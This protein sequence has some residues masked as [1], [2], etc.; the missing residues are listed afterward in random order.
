M[1]AVTLLGESAVSSV[2]ISGESASTFAAALDR[3]G[4]PHDFVEFS[5]FQHVEVKSG[6]G[7]G[8]LLGDGI[9]LYR[10]VYALLEPS[11]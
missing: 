3:L 1:S 7:L 4:K 5:I 6:L 9:R 11:I 2:C 8:P 10:V